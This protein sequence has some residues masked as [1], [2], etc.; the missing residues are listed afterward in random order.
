MNTFHITNRL[1]KSTLFCG[2]LL[3]SSSALSCS[4]DDDGGGNGGTQLEWLEPIRVASYNIQY[5]NR[6]EEAGRWENRKEIVCRLLEAEDF[7]IF[8]AQEPYKFQIEDMAAALPGYTWIGTSVTGEDNVE[9]RHFN[10]IFYKTDKFEVLESGSFWYSETPNVPNTKFS[11]SYSPRMCNWAH[12]RVKATGKEFFLF[13]SHFDHIGTVARAESAKLLIEKVAETAGKTPAFCTGD[14]NSNQQTNVYN[15][16]VTSGTLVD[17]YA[18]T[19]DKVNADWPSYNGY[20]YISTPPAKASR[21][22]HIFV[23][24]GRTKVQSWAIVNTS[25]SQKYPS[26]HFPVVIEWSFAK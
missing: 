16:I 17:S 25:Y 11:D 10:P 4:S 19:T 1:L 26:D 2:L 6:N 8:G 13:N 3:F 22:D 21:I 18:R 9:R 24:K 7:D 23:T 14:F 20:K 15:T 12:F 5:D